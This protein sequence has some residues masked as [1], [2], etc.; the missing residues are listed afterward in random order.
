M[1]MIHSA[2]LMMNPGSEL[3]AVLDTDKHLIDNLAGLGFGRCFYTHLDQMLDQVDLDVV[4]ICT[5]NQSH[6]PIAA[7]CLKQGLDIFVEMPLS[8]SYSSAMSMLQLAAQSEVLH[9]VGYT[10]PFEPIFRK[11]KALVADQAVGKI[12]RFRSSFYWSLSSEIPAN[13]LLNK[14]IS[15]GGVVLNQASSLLYLIRWLFGPVKSLMARTSHRIKDVEDNASIIMHFPAGFIGLVDISWNRPGYPHPATRC[16]IEGSL[17]TMEVHD[18]AIKLYLYKKTEKFEKGWTTID[19]SDLPAPSSLFLGEE[20]YYEGS[21][22]FLDCVRQ[23][24]SHSVSWEQGF[25]VMRIVE[26]IYRSAQKKEVIPMEEINS[27]KNST[28]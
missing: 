27:W 16:I 25:E 18:D 22:V 21:R 23:R 9:A 26:A 7:K 20:G 12:K 28:E 3:C 24:K 13:W 11:A 4:F 15:G 8:D 6:L 14:S 5:P 2:A 10:I 17:G 19:K 1:G